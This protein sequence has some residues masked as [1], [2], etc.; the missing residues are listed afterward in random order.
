LIS[1]DGGTTSCHM[2]VVV[3][4]DDVPPEEVDGAV[5]LGPMTPALGWDAEGPPP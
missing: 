5:G 2:V 1:P 3:E 4:V